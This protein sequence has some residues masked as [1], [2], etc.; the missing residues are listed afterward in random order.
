[1]KGPLEP[2]TSVGGVGTMFASRGWHAGRL[3][4]ITRSAASDQPSMTP[5]DGMDDESSDRRKKG[6]S[7]SGGYEWTCPYCGKSRLNR[8]DD[9]AGLENAKKAL[10]THIIASDDADH[11]PRNAFPSDEMVDLSEHVVEVDRSWGEDSH[12]ND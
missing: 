9:E 12:I 6:T 2:G 7:P 1:M 5:I 4:H 11:G 8:S 3:P 10:R